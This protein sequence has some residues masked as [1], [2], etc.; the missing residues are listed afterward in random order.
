MSAP[1]VFFAIECGN[2]YLAKNT[3]KLDEDAPDG[4][5]A[6]IAAVVLAASIAQ[7]ISNLG[8]HE[9]GAL[10][11][12]GNLY[13]LDSPVFELSLYV[14]LGLVSGL[15]SVIFTKLRNLFTTMFTGDSWASDWPKLPFYARPLIGGLVCGLVGMFFPQTL[16]VGYTTLDQLIAGKIE[17]GTPLII[18]LLALKVFLSAFSLGSGLI[19]KFNTIPIIL[20]HSCVLD[21][22]G[23]VFAPALFFGAAVGSAYQ[24]LMSGVVFNILEVVSTWNLD[25]KTLN[26]FFNFFTIANAPAYATVGAAA[27]LGSLFRAPLTS[28]MLLFEL[29]QNHDIVLPVLISTGLGGLFAE[30][31]SQPRR[32]W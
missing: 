6:D 11:I 8:L 18:E 27:T 3:V 26:D 19:G 10:A 22:K 9:R 28:S 14:G 5:R 29:T 15:V 4:P 32:Q 21:L 30:L 25:E 7:L 12:Q 23:G 2:R 20:P 16:F 13:A 1:G 24:K 31:I 17:L